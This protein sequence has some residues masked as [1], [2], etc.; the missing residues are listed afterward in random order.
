MKQKDG[1]MISCKRATELVEIQ[2][3]KKLSFKQQFQLKLHLLLCKVC[4]IY[5]K[6]S[7]KL[8]QMILKFV[9]NKS[10]VI[11]PKDTEKLKSEII[12]KLEKIDA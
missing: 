9:G 3:E 6:Q 4:D 1:M 10:E 12:E 2:F 8:N 7:A 5:A 11:T